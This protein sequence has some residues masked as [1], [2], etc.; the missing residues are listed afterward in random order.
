[1]QIYIVQQSNLTFKT[2]LT[3]PSMKHAYSHRCF[4]YKCLDIK[5]N[6][7]PQK[8]SH[9]YIYAFSKYKQRDLQ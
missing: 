1:M 2:C 5:T 3:C 8:A 6:K 9:I 4:L 7:Q